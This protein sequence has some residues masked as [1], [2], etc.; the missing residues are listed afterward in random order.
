MTTDNFFNWINKFV[1]KC[2]RVAPGY[3]RQRKR[4]KGRSKKNRRGRGGGEIV[5]DNSYGKNDNE[6]GGSYMLVILDET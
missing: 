2:F 5:L 6:D 3:W 1:N 4:G